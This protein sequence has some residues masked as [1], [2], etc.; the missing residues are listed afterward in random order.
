MNQK[1]VSPQDLYHLRQA[2][3]VAERQALLAQQ[4]QNRAKAI[5]LRIELR[6]GL[7]ASEARLDIATGHITE[8]GRSTE[9]ASEVSYEPG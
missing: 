7:L 9:R 4:A 2:L 8:A 5:L 6:Y 3:L 1:K